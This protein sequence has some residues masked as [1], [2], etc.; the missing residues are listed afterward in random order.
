M[1]LEQ[2]KRNSQLTLEVLPLSIWLP[3]KEENGVP[4]HIECEL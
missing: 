4:S 3:F 2:E 1:T